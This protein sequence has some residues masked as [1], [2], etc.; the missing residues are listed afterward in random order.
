M[1]ISTWQSWANVL[2]A[3]KTELGA[4]VMKLEVTD[5]MII[6]KLYE[7]V[8]PEF[9]THSGYH[10][11][12]KMTQDHI[13]SE[14]PVIEYQFKD[15][16]HRIVGI[17]GKVDK[18]SYIDMQMN[19]L[20]HMSGDITEF[21]VRQNYLDMSNMVRADNT[22]RFVGPDKLQ[23]VKAGLSYI[24][25]EFILELDCIHSDPST[26]DSTLYREFIDLS[27]A[28]CLNWIGKIRKKYNNVATPYGNIE[29][30][31]DDMINEARDLRRDTLEKLLRT[32]SDQLIWVL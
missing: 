18:S 14:E 24:S 1:S 30:N 29:L 12:Y 13:I 19:Q 8:L 7:H 32:P 15:F 23:I 2:D 6:K 26:I 9:S 5:Q 20:Q 4:D 17:K 16:D 3:V 28:Y 10:C 11:Y 31:A 22:Y 25:D 27:I 21:L